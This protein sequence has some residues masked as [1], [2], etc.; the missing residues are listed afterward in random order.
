MKAA[1]EDFLEVLDDTLDALEM[2]GW[3]TATLR[4]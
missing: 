4:G 1:S 3:A 2:D